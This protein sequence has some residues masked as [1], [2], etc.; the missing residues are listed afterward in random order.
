[1]KHVGVWEL[2]HFCDSNKVCVFVGHVI[3][4]ELQGTTHGM[5]NVYKKNERQLC[6]VLCPYG[7]SYIGQLSN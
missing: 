7:L 4:T 5:E 1:M 3:T 6:K 2:K